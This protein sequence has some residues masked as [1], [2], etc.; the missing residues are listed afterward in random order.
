MATSPYFKVSQATELMRK[1]RYTAS[2][3][4]SLNHDPMSEKFSTP[5][6]PPGKSGPLKNMRDSKSQTAQ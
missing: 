2:V 3:E 6:Y 4:A 1:E 5:A